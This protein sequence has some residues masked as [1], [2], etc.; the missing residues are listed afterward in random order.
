MSVLLRDIY[1]GDAVWKIRHIS[2]HDGTTVHDTI[3]DARRLMD[4]LS[5]DAGDAFWQLEWSLSDAEWPV[6]EVRGAPRRRAIFQ[7]T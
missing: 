4:G 3:L 2:V 1:R 6:P 7:L 5:S